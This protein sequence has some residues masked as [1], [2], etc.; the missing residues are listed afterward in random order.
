MGSAWRDRH[1]ATGSKQNGA[2]TNQWSHLLS[3]SSQVKGGHVS[4]GE[5]PALTAPLSPF[6][7]QFIY[8]KINKSKTKQVIHFLPRYI[9]MA[10]LSC[11]PNLLQIR[12]QQ[13]YTLPS[14]QSNLRSCSQCASLTL[15]FYCL[16][17]FFCSFLARHQHTH[18]LTWRHH[19]PISKHHTLTLEIHL[20]YIIKLSGCECEK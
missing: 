6:L 1:D 13:V 11:R 14:D 17:L 9:A 15:Q 5:P 20:M 19:R 3:S 8:E 2:V 4:R 7:L 10:T 16:V 18:S 12:D